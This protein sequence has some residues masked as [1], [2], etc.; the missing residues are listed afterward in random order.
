MPKGLSAPIARYSGEQYEPGR[1]SLVSNGPAIFSLY[2]P[3]GGMPS[4]GD[5]SHGIPHDRHPYVVPPRSR[6]EPPAPAGVLLA[7]EA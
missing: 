3:S 2:Q 5:V 4:R 7:E 6:C 1:T